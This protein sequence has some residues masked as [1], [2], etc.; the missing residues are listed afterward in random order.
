MEE[1]ISASSKQVMEGDN[2]TE[3]EFEGEQEEGVAK[4]AVLEL[5]LQAKLNDLL[6]KIKSIEIKLFS[7]AT[8]EFVK[9]LK[10]DAGAELLRHYVQ[11]SPSLSE[12]LEAWKLRQGK[13]GMSYV[14]TLISAILCHPDGRRYNDKLGVSRVLDKFARLI[15][16]E[17]LEDVYKEL[18][19]KDWKRQN[20]ALLLMGSVVR[21]GSW[22]ASEVAKKFD[23][24]LQGFPKF[25]EY[26]RR[27]QIDKKKHSTRRSFVGFA[28][29]FL[30]MGKP[31]LL[32]WVLQQRDM[33]SGVLRCLGN[34]DDETIMYILATLRDRVLI[35]ESLVPPGLRSVLFGSVTLEQLVYISGRENG[36]FAAELAYSVLLMVCT[37]PSNGLMPD[38][39]RKP[40]PL[41][42]NPTRLLGVMQKLKATEVS[43]HKDL[44][45]FTLKGRPSLAAAYMNEFPYTVE[46]H[47][48][49][50]WFSTIS[51]AASLISSVAMGNPFDFLDGKSDPPSFDSADV[52]D[53][54]NCICPRPLSRSVVTKGLLHSD[55][56]VKHGALRLLLEALKLLDSF[57]SSLNHI[58]CVRNQMMESWVSLKQAVQ[59]EV[60]TLLPDT[61]VLLTLLSSLGSHGRTPKSSLKRKP[62]LE[63]FP[64][65]S[66]SKKLKGGAP[67]EDSDI[68]VGGISSDPDI[69]MPEDHDMVA[70]DHMI[71]ELDTE[72]EFLNVISEIWGLCLN[73]SPFM[74]LKDVEMYFYSKLVDTLKIYLRAVP[75][76]LEGS[77][78]FFMNLLSNPSALPI[79]LQCSLLSLL[80]EYIGWSPGNG[81]SN[82][83]PLLMYR[84]LQTFINLLILSP[85]SE[86]KNQAYILARAAMLSTGA[87]DRNLCEIDAWFLFLPGYLRTKSPI[88]MQAV[89][90]LQ[91][92]SGVVIS[93]LGDAIST[94]GNNLFKHWDI[95]RQHISCLKGFKGAGISPNFSPL[96]ICALNKCLRLLN[97][98]SGTFSLSE[99]SMISL[100]VCNTLKYVLQIQV[101]AGLLSDL[102]QSVLSKGL[103][104]Q[105]SMVYDSG[106]FLCEWRPL[107]SLLYFSQNA[108]HQQPQYFLSVDKTA[109]A[110]DSSFANTL[111][112]VK[113]VITYEHGGEVTG[114]VKAFYSAM[115]CATLEDLLMNFPL[116]M[117]ISLKLGVAVPLL[118]SVIFSEQNFLVGISNLWPEVFFPGLELALMM[119]HQKG[120]DDA[121]GMF[122]NIDFDTIESAATAFGLLLKQ[123]PFHI[124]FSSLISI[125][126]LYLSE[127][128]KIQDLLL[129]K[130]SEWTSDYLISCLRLVLF[131][132][133][134]VRSFYRNK[135]LTEL[136]Q[137]SDTCLIL[138]KNMFSQL[139]ALKPEFECSTDSEV[140]LSV[141]T[142]REVAETILC[143]PEVM[144]SLT[145]P[146]SWNK[147]ESQMATGLLGNALDNFLSLSRQR[148]P[149]LDRQ[150][151]DLLTA[152]LDYYLT[153]SR[154]HYSVIDDGAKRTF[155][156]AFSSLVQRLFL[157]IRDRF[158]LCI[159]SG[160]LQP[161]LSSFCA[162]HALIESLS[163]FELLDLGHWMFSR[164]DVN[165]L[166]VEKFHVKVALSVSFSI[167]VGTFEVLST[168]LQQPLI[169]RVPYDFLWE[170]EEKTFDVNLLEDI[171]VKACK[172]A[173]N[174]K[175]DF[176]D[177]CLLRAV[178]AVYRQKTMHHGE[179]HP[180]SILMSRAI[181]STPVE[182]VS[183]CI[184]RT[185]TVKAK[186][187]HLV[188][189][190]SPLHLS[191]FGQLF[192]SILNKNFLS[193][194]FLMEE[195]SIY[196]LSDQDYMVLLPAALSLVNAAFVKFEKHF[197][198]HFKSIPSFYS[199]ILLNGFMHWKSFVS[200]D[201]FQEDYS[202]T[203]P[204]SAEE[205][206]NLV[207]GSLLRK[208]IH[209]LRY[210]F[211]LSGDSLKLKK[212]LE[213]FNSIFACSVTP[214]ELIECDATEM[215]FNS[216]NKSLNHINKVIAKISFCRML[217]F[218]EDDKLLFMPE[219]ADE[220]FKEA[221]LISGSNK[222]DS[223]RKHFLNALVG[224]WQWMV[225]K[226]PLVPQYS[227]SI[228][229]SGGDC[230][231]LYRCF[232]VFIL[233][234]ILQL[235]SKMHSYLIQ[236]QSI[237][238]VEQLMRSTLLHRFEDSKTLRILR[239]ILLLLSEGKFSRVL[240]LQRLLG[241]SQFGPMIHSIS[242]SSLLE[243]GT[244]FR[245]LSS[246]LRL[247][248]T[249][250]IPSDMMDGKDDQET[251][252]ICMK[253][254]EILKILRILL[255]SGFDSGNDNG[256]NLKE[257]HFLLLSSYG[258]TLGDID[259][260]IY[261][262]MDV[263]ESFH[264]SGSE[265]ITET[266]YLWGSAATKVK[267]E[268]LLEHGAS[269]DTMTDTEAVQEGRK[270]KYRENLPVDPNISA[271]TVLHFPYDR[272]A[273]EEHLSSNKFQTDNL[274]DMIELRSPGT[275]KILRYDP[276]FIMHF[277]IHSLSAGYIEPVEFAGLGLLAVAFVGMSS[278]DVGMR[279]LAYGVL[280]RFKISLEGCQKKKDVIRL[281]LLLMYMQNGIEEPWQR[282]PSVIALFAAE[283]SLILLDT[284]HEHYSTLNKLLM[285]SSR[286]NIKQIPLFHDFF[287]SSAVNY[288][289]KRLWILRLAYAGLNLEDDAWLYIRSS[290]PET[291]MSFYVSPLSDV[292]SKKLIL[293]VL[294]KS[295]QL[296]EMA[297]YLV[298]HCS[299]FPWLSSILSTY[300]RVLL[301]DEK[302]LFLTELA[303]VIE[304]VSLVISSNDI[305]KWLQSCALEQLMELT[306]HLYKLLVGGMKLINECAAFINP[307]LQ[308][309]IA[310]LKMSQNRQ[311]YQPCFTLSHEVLFQIYLAVSEDDIGGSSANAKCALEA[312]L[313]IGPPFDIFCMN[314]EN[315]SSFLMR[316]ASTA[317]KSYSRKLF[318]CQESGLHVPIVSKEASHKESFTSKFL[319]WL[320]ASIIHWKLYLNSNNSTAKLSDRSN[321]KTLQSLLEYVAEGDKEGNKSSFDLE[322]MLAAQIFY[323]Q[324][325]LGINCSALPS[326]VSAL[327]LLLCDHS[328]FT[329]SDFMHD[330]RTS[331]VTLCSKIRCPPELNPA[332]RWSFEHPWEDQSSQL[333]D[334][335]R[336]DELHACQ[337]LLLIISNV[338]R[339]KSSDFQAL[340]LQD[341]DNSGAF[342]WE[343]SILETE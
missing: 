22:L 214:E 297:H 5:S 320:T 309:I 195:V 231:C 81:K 62:G 247:L 242:K 185:S 68:I 153:V 97:S 280:A 67:K 294:K 108:L 100:Y 270:I 233:R 24:K 284:L 170:V 275:G 219:E 70:D 107:K 115:L 228:I 176:A 332:W 121:E 327:C 262:L 15:V 238:F 77:F 45:L 253:Q 58:S 66:S 149:K 334:L 38:L 268:H 85:N 11:T 227:T 312:I 293:Q 264:S 135:Q 274:M 222:V 189:E 202:K 340:S 223:S 110:N 109:I 218:P 209:M 50:T 112:E 258:A 83:I 343:R 132:L 29:S 27:K 290:I 144:S 52:Q 292:E 211:L 146:L 137:L 342:K 291:L 19:S 314:R 196:A 138:V 78:D 59:N 194:G 206:F 64:E 40:N 25:S 41:K 160:N 287:H 37:D 159:A 142:M 295:V 318:Q 179:L 88:E 82:S 261:S 193:N 126:A 39:D 192:L 86:I 298:E 125:H 48:S 232:E 175:L 4:T 32:R 57:V 120:N 191:I 51:L 93:F 111:G 91:S 87:F 311:M 124:L 36:G 203:L 14:F 286:V 134:H 237:P 151:L 181:I 47:A 256:I 296:H 122:S 33:Y 272:T 127:H 322:E 325:S 255:Q 158:D 94:I 337:S 164:I 235:T 140:H 323:L 31:G 217:L 279:K 119:I 207:D 282:I 208:S 339:K 216:V 99:K 328:K 204:S 305:A 150:V 276:V 246:I 273:T 331:M 197:Y 236:L 220:G 3:S 118:S 106:D 174:F 79:N 251:A 335:E 205:L 43:Y 269:T 221:S 283:A 200:R 302:K 198:Q 103:G 172:I 148:L 163:P 329:G 271:A 129:A 210:H 310:T 187:L 53:I 16:D 316:A 128:S 250:P 20:A 9:F 6:H 104:D 188:I 141:E 265:Y 243:T 307:T 182:M 257:L 147:E 178:S 95:V 116:V 215:D 72:K 10:S 34:D 240:C 131:W 152:T 252:E 229:A 171:Y 319:R 266:D 56:F 199:R 74:E 308:I 113:K 49:P 241:H 230:L 102:I 167:A 84:H 46:D 73:S 289:A 133:Y 8:K 313:L 301:G 165:E 23:F 300:S 139:L 63:K 123:V 136:E 183:H 225:K 244:F 30:E 288:K 35:K 180:S 54:V 278:L 239:S 89:E 76:I 184:R 267:K 333:N 260:E 2:D 55:F 101:D 249:P 26:K 90:V 173:C 299:L 254:L 201:I 105:H 161:L 224:A 44:L 12:L 226:L 28:M 168:Y 177:S 317:L 281:H 212:R 18:N 157:D 166:T 75:T 98:S 61:Q 156:R 65:N 186:L 234:S 341:I 145:C 155:R 326:V 245:P 213:L 285:D 330:C 306:S 21:R 303:V 1:A 42:G 190:M 13:P 60:R 336:I 17:K 130:R 169:K 69:S 117:T 154:R 248:V 80:I 143:H 71:D 315:I 162:V 277:S 321:L 7:D 338:L 324:Q 114:I 259:L 263:I 96:T 304:I 92:L